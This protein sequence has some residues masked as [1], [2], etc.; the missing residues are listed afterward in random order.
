[1]TE[2]KINKQQQEGSR[3]TMTKNKD[4]E[5]RGSL[6]D[7]L[8]VILLS[9]GVGNDEQFTSHDTAAEREE[10]STKRTSPANF[11]YG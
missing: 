8:K 1:M 7:F 2:N 6:Y 9:H 4:G 11:T 3:K 10:F 5:H